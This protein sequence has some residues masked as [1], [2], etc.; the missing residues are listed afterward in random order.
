MGV[1]GYITEIHRGALDDGPGVRTVVFFKGCPLRCLWCHN[2]ETQNPMPEKM[3]YDN[4]RTIISGKL[5][6]VPEVMDVVRKDVG[7]YIATGGGL[8]VTGGEPLAQPEFCAKLLLAAKE[9]NIHTCVETCGMAD[10]LII[11]ET[12]LYT[13][14]WLFDIKGFPYDY[15]R[16]T[17]KSFDKIKSAL[18][19]LIESG[20]NVTIRCPVVPGIHNN[21]EYF[22]YL[23]RLKSEYPGI[24]GIELLP[25]H[26]FGIDKY[27]AL[28][29]TAPMQDKQ[30]ED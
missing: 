4:G 14:L 17:G 27:K 28:G 11:K 25:F 26:R 16:L 7:H 30:E 19:T 29:R 24:N 13:D 18:H 20:A 22:S 6:T 9:E 12:A 2:P 10:T 3:V 21:D 23:D 15:P 5:V 1:Q 8:T